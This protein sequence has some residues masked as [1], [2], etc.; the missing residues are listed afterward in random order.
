MFELLRDKTLLYPVVIH[1]SIC[2]IAAVISSRSLSWTICANTFAL[3]LF[4]SWLLNGLGF[5]CLLLFTLPFYLSTLPVALCL[6]QTSRFSRVARHFS[7]FCLCSHLYLSVLLVF[8]LHQFF[9]HCVFLLQ[10]HYLSF[11]IS[12]HPTPPSSLT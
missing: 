4:L 3:L 1:S 7:L 8:P 10:F 2:S 9:L 5:L 12:S 6:S 11:L